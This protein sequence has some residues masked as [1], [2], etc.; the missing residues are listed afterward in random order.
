MYIE[1]GSIIPVA[2]NIFSEVRVFLY[3]DCIKD[4]LTSVVYCRDA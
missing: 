2:Y 4:E 3:T 1:I